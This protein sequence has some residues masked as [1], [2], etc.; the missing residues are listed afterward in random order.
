MATA[1]D[2][3]SGGDMLCIRLDKEDVVGDLLLLEVDAPAMIRSPSDRSVA[4]HAGPE[5]CGGS[6][7]G[8]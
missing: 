3:G 4:F 6:R 7:K 5:F 1:A 2:S 8:R